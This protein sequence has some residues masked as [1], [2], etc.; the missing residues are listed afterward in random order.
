MVIFYFELLYLIFFTTDN[1]TI[2]II[3]T[4]EH[5]FQSYD[6]SSSILMMKTFYGKFTDGETILSV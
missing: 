2:R 1:V 5:L 3:A 6:I 4:N